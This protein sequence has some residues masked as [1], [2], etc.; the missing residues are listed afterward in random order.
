MDMYVF[1]GYYLGMKKKIVYVFC[2]FIPSRRLRHRLH[3][4]AKRR[5]AQN[6]VIEIVLLLQGCRQKLSK[7][8]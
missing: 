3:D 8:M 4:W 6:N 2:W 5:K 1:L 7:K